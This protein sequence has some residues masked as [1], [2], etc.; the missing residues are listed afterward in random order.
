MLDWNRQPTNKPI[1]NITVHEG[2]MTFDILGGGTKDNH[3]VF[4]P[5][6]YGCTIAPE[7]GS[8]SPVAT[9]GSFHFRINIAE[10]HSQSNITVKSNGQTISPAGDIYTLSNIQAD[11]IVT[12][13]GLKFNTVPIS[14]S[15]G[16]NGTISPSGVVEVPVNNVQHFDITPNLGFSVED[17]VVDGISE[18]PIRH[19][20][21]K[22][23]T[24]PH[25]ISA[26]YKYGDKYFIY[27][28]P[29][30]VQFAT[31]PGLPS[32]SKIVT[33]TSSQ[34]AGN[35]M[36]NTPEKFEISNNGTQWYKSFVVSR[37]QLPYQLFVRY[38]PEEDDRENALGKITLCSVEAYAEIILIG[39]ITLD[40][41]ENTDSNITVYP[42]PTNGELQVTSYELQVT[43]IEIFDV[44][45]R[46]LLLPQL[47]IVN[48]QL[49]IKLNIS[50][51]QSGIY[52]LA[53]KTESNIYYEKIIKY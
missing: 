16:A 36:I 40:I 20:V 15:A 49:S 3:L 6:Y 28:S 12:M 5:S 10:S 22:N 24:E 52:L 17:V 34:L 46:K 42:N 1:T 32:Q 51:L 13:E 38:I 30:I 14:T 47:S 45:G 8:V 4:L 33:I 21:F 25:T 35:I 48:S 44:F 41:P 29:N 50:H 7:P 37:T 19:Y 27:P 18:G 26:R 31:H 39:N 43:N 9:G 23:V 2:Y 11:Q 53:I